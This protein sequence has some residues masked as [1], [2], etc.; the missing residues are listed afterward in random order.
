MAQGEEPV[1]EM[2]GAIQAEEKASTRFRGDRSAACV[3]GKREQA[4]EWRSVS[5]QG[6]SAMKWSSRQ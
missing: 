1:L 5:G 2:G 4:A 3:R 6:V